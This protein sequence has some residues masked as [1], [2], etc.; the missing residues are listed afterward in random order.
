MH[1]YSSLVIALGSLSFVALAAPASPSSNTSSN[2]VVNS[3]VPTLL[4]SSS[5]PVAARSTSEKAHT[6]AK[7]TSNKTSS[8]KHTSKKTSVKATPTCQ[9]TTT[10][11]AKVHFCPLPPHTPPVNPS[12][13]FEDLPTSTPPP[14]N[15]GGLTWSGFTVTDASDYL[16]LAASGSHVI[17]SAA[18]GSSVTV[19]NVPNEQSMLTIKSFSFACTTSPSASFT[20]PGPC[21]MQMIA[22][23]YTH[24]MDIESY[25]PF[26]SSTVFNGSDGPDNLLRMTRVDLGGGGATGSL[27]AFNIVSGPGFSRLYLDEVVVERLQQCD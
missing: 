26:V 10:Y 17:E 27:F 11:T 25:G 8:V 2:A 16:F 5:L 9:P 18:L 24:I 1:V 23:P 22:E 15:Y 3:S 12:S 14:P 7:P 4:P 20:A 21:S 6:T 13:Q 19:G